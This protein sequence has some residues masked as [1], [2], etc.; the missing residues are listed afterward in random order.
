MIPVPSLLTFI[1]LFLLFFP[2]VLTAGNVPKE[3]GGFK[4]GEDIAK[5]P[6]VESSNYLQEVVITEWHG[7]RRGVISYGSCAY[8]GKI[9]R[10]H[11]K[12]EDSSKN[13]YKKLLREFK[14]R[15]GEPAEWSGDAFG[16]LF[17]WKWRFIDENN[18]RVNLT[19]QH[20]LKDHRES[21]GNT[22]K[23]YF[24]AREEEERLCFN[25]KCE[26]WKSDKEKEEIE[27]RKQMDWD[28]LIPK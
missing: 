4:I 21:I 9:V 1:L 15:F 7:F 2:T 12:Y 13:F 16:I 19:L 28:Y 24:P 22:V 18:E 14:S 23:L 6:E 11:L 20:N 5:Y 26:L 17:K 3:L 25:Q 27:N 8:P 10:I